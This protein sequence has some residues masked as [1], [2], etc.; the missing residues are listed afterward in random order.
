MDECKDCKYF[1][2]RIPAG[3]D[4]NNSRTQ[5]LKQCHRFPP[6]VAS[7]AAGGEP[8][9]IWPAVY[10]NDWCGEFAHRTAAT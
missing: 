1:V 2:D 9:S 3:M 6:S 7:R 5:L 8:V 10:L 4:P